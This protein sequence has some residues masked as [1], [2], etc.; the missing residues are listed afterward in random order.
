MRQDS[1]VIKSTN[2]GAKLMDFQLNPHLHV[3]GHWIYNLDALGFAS[4][5]Q[6]FNTNT[7]KSNCGLIK[8]K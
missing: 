8:L 7:S 6:G 5:K 4:T 1:V 3:V 2:S